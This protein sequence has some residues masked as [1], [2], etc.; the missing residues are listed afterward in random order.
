[1]NSL[2][3]CAGLL[4]G[5]LLV[6]APAAA[7]VEHRPSVFPGKFIEQLIPAKPKKKRFARYKHHSTLVM[8]RAQAADAGKNW[9]PSLPE[10]PYLALFVPALL[11]AGY[12]GVRGSHGPWPGAAQKGNAP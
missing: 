12:L 7:S 8:E 10:A 1:M 2:H 11:G 3:F 6:M 5:S 9:I 4:C